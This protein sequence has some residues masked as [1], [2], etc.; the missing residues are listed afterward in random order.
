M[1]PAVMSVE[2]GCVSRRRQTKPRNIEE[3]AWRMGAAC[4]ESVGD[5]PVKYCV[6]HVTTARKQQHFLSNRSPQ[7]MHHVIV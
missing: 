6:L 4:S 7:L 3:L 5:M 2:G 1:P